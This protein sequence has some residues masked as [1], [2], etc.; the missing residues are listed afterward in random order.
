MYWQYICSSAVELFAVWIQ[1]RF[2]TASMWMDLMILS[3]NYDNGVWIRIRVGRK[4]EIK[5][6]ISGDEVNIKYRM[7]KIIQI[8]RFQSKIGNWG[9]ERETCGLSPANV[10]ICTSALC[11]DLLCGQWWCQTGEC[12]QRQS[13][14]GHRYV[15]LPKSPKSNLNPRR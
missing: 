2:F 5:L 15:N 11:D 7:M 8:I 12:G 1:Q 13:S 4:L 9:R 14:Y 6:V 3:C 10:C